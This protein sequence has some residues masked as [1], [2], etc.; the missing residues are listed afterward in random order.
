MCVDVITVPCVL[1]TCDLLQTQPTTCGIRPSCPTQPSTTAPWTTS[2]SCPSTMP[3]R[4]QPHPQGRCLS[5]LPLGDALPSFFSLVSRHKSHPKSVTVNQIQF[6]LEPVHLES[7]SVTVSQVQFLPVP[8]HPESVS[9]TVSQVQFLLVPV[10]H[11]SVSV[12][13]SQ[14]QFLP[15]PVHPEFGSEE[16]NSAA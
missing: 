9:V 15:V 14:V 1:L 10:H 7:V 3:G 11:E 16:G 6:Q 8:V 4:T 12:T 2:T 5:L 13:V